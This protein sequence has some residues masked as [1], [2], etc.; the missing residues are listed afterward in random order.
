M[1][2]NK[3]GFITIFPVVLLSALLL[4][5]LSV[6]S[7]SILNSLYMYTQSED[8]QESLH[9][10][11]SC[12]RLA[13]SKY[14]INE[15]YLGNEDIQINNRNCHVDLIDRPNNSV[16]VE[17][18]VGNSHSEDTIIFSVNDLKILSEEVF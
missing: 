5:V 1:Q 9:M 11:R 14:M 7:L 18:L 3:N 12:A 6:S 16:T 8:K 2:K 15:S 4:S 17:V 10:A 13:L